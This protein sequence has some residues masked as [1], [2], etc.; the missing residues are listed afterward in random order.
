M[1]EPAVVT[2]L[3]R[4]PVKSFTPE[5]RDALNILNNGRVQG[6][7]VLA[8]QLG[9]A[10]GA[11]R[12]ATGTGEGWWPKERFICLMTTPGI[13][14]LRL[15]FDD[16]SR[17]MRIEHAGE[18]LVETNI[19]D[20][21]GRTE[22]AQAVE[23]FVRTLD[24]RPN[25]DRAGR[26]PLHVVGDGELPRFHDYPAGYVT[27]HSRA[28]LQALGA[29]LDDDALDE[30]RFRS[31]VVVDGLDAGEELGWVD[32][33]VRI[34]DMRFAATRLVVRC[35][36]THASPSEGMRDREVLKTLPQ[37]NGHKKPVFAVALTPQTSGVIRLGAEL[38]VE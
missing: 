14:R 30:R 38:A 16:A 6:D 21:T 4:Y 1:I 36:A 26:T 29:A 35:L 22:I 19:D 20:A 31:N 17:R 37:V 28:S 23:A 34:G 5:Q 32:R 9:D 15:H 10:G 27:L 13:A 12:E 33:T 3:Y 25:L 18:V 24:E 11:P 8:V 7:R 2:R